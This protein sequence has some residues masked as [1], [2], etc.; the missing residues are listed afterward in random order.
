M[1]ELAYINQNELTAQW[2]K[3]LSTKLFVYYFMSPVTLYSIQ[4]EPNDWNVIQYVSKDI[5]GK[6]LG[7]FAAYINR[8]H[9]YIENIDIIN[10]TEAFH[11]TFSKDIKNFFDLLFTERGYRKIVFHTLVKNPAVNMYKRVIRR[12]NLGCIVGILKENRCLPDGS[13]YDEIVFE[14]YQKNYLE[15]LS[16]GINKNLKP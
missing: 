2:E 13:Y 12:Y 11:V 9:M 5:N 7:F 1:L 6:I 4:I 16:K 10:F 3:T 8:P 15:F 14:L